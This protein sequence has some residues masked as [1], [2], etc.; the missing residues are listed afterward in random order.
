[1]NRP[2]NNGQTDDIDLRAEPPTLREWAF[3]LILLVLG[4]ALSML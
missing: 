4:L 3:V 1:M 2:K